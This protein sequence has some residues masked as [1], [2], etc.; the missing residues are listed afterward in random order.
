MVVM[1]SLP[2]LVPAALQYVTGIPG[3]KQ[4]YVSEGRVTAT[5]SQKQP[6][7]IDVNDVANLTG[8]SSPDMRPQ[9]K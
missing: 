1:A 3:P 2:T 4:S 7:G 6:V 8:E 5:R 9:E